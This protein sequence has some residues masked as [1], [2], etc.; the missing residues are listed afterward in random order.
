M[1]LFPN[2]KINLGLDILRRRID[3]FHDIETVMYPVYGLYD[4]LEIIRSANSGAEFSSSGLPMDC[5]PEK[6]L[7]VRAYE[8]MRARYGIGGVKIHL[9]KAIPSGAG[10]GGG[11]ADAAFTLAGLNGLFA[12]G[13]GEA[14]LESL[15]AELGSDTAFFI[16]NAP[17]FCEGRGEVMSPADMDLSGKYLLLIKPSVSVSTAEAYA[18]V[19]PAIPATG[20]C[21]RI[22]LPLEEWRGSVENAFEKSVFARY[23]VLGE[24]KQA[25]YDAGAAYAAMSGS[26]SAIFGIFDRRPEKL[27]AAADIESQFV[28]AL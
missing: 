8:L 11:S 9:H 19:V 23:P 17:R 1:L 6:N 18:G 2:C 4:G 12:L 13:C 16:R 28:V 5:P 20:L 24:L 21:E 27:A 3:G 7:V 15:A 22:A 25:L 26:G 14:E 10:L